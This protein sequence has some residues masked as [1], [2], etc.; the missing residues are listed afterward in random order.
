[1]YFYA[2]EN[3]NE[4]HSSV[5]SLMI[6]KISAIF[7]S[8]EV[9]L[10]MVILACCIEHKIPINQIT[11]P[12]ISSAHKISFKHHNPYI[13]TW[14]ELQS[15]AISQ[16]D[17]TFK[18]RF[19]T[20]LITNHRGLMKKQNSVNSHTDDLCTCNI[21]NQNMC[22]EFHMSRRQYLNPGGSILVYFVPQG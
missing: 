22:L 9:N 10:H 18:D 4:Q 17:P 13:S 6:D 19:Q 5:Y 14:S 11:L 8:Q 20:G 7:N 2:P 1:M 15:M 12:Q 21:A 3:A 16:F